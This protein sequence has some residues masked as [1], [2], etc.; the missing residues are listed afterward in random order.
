M[1]D[2]A[3]T[4]ASQISGTVLTPT[5]EGYKESLKRWAENAQ[6]NAAYV[7]YVE[8]AEDISKT[9]G[10]SAR[11]AKKDSMGYGQQI[12]FGDQLWWAL[13]RRFLVLRRGGS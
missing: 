9:V 5:D 6:R 7:V 12:G 2:N 1:V 3:T 11:S 13:G 10:S 8:S 4:L